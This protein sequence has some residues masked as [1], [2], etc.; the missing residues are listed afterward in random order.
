MIYNVDFPNLKPGDLLRYYGI[1][2]RLVVKTV[3]VRGDWWMIEF[4]SGENIKSIDNPA[5]LR[6]FS[7]LCPECK[8][9]AIAPHQAMCSSCVDWHLRKN[10]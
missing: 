9:H 4:T 3:D 10:M 5:L 6:D 2:Q 8:K 1:D 7:K